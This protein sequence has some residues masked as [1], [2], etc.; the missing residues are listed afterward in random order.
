ME[1]RSYQAHDELAVLT[2]WERCDLTRPWN[3]PQKDIQRK[4]QI[5]PEM[6]LVGLVDGVVIAS[7]MAGYDG[8][9]GWVN[10][11]AVDP[12]HRHQGLGRV[13]MAEAEQLLLNTGCPKLNLQIRETNTE[14][15]QF[16]E[17]LGYNVDKVLSMGKRLEKDH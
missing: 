1:I 10:Y 6:F 8:H 16:Y 9:R 2:L 3:D 17:K 7:V 13:L 15:I 14:A 12:D 5:Q 4:L 11:L